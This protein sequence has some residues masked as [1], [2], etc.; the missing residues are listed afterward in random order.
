MAGSGSTL[1]TK[2]RP[3][4]LDQLVGHEAVIASLSRRLESDSRPHCFLFS[5][6][7]GVG[8]TTTARIIGSILEADV[9]EVDAASNSG[10]D[11]MRSLTDISMYM[12]MSGAGHR[13]LII[14][15]CHRLSS[16]AW[17]ALL[18]LLEEPPAHLYIALCTTALDKVPE[19]IKTRCY[20]VPFKPLPPAEIE[21]L[22]TVVADMEGWDV[23]P[24]I[25]ALA[26]QAATGQP[27]KGLT[28]LEQIHDYRSRDEARRVIDLVEASD[29]IIELLQ[30]LLSGKKSWKQIRA[31]L[32]RLEDSDFE[33]A[34]IIAG[35][36]IAGALVRCEEE[37]AAASAWALLDA[38]LFPSSTYDKK[39]AF[40][41]AVGRM[42]WGQS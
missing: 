29:P 24:D 15:E 18:K 39:T 35:R 20:H 23:H 13:L 33:A 34:A 38:L 40:L 3:D 9:N 41:A 19:T 21:A 17:D 16:N 11:A 31:L 6:P 30:H 27:R 37:K 36:Y 42:L 8:K 7:S 12:S 25:L 10:V 26:V 32:A 28:I 14:D 4:A 22:L 2:Y 5:G 1:L